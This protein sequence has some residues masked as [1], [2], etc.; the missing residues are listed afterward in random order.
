M[1]ISSWPRNFH[2]RSLTDT[3]RADIYGD[4]ENK[5]FFVTHELVFETNFRKKLSF[6]L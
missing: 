2:A 4:Q 1:I 6:T 5:I 3:T